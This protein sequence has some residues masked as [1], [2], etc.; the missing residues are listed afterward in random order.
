MNSIL[1]YYAPGD[2]I[3]VERFLKERKLAKYFSRETAAAVVSLGELL[4]RTP[5]DKAAPAYYGMGVV[6]HESFGLDAIAAASAGEGGGF[7]QKLF[8]EEGFM[9]VPPL[10]QF[11]VLYNMPLCFASIVFGLTGDNAVIYSSAAGLLRQ[12]LLAPSFPVLLGAGKSYTDGSVRACFAL[13]GR[14]ELEALLPLAGDKEAIEIFT[15][16]RP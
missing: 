1:N 13:A 4:Q 3:P 6:D 8:V 15:L 10:N 9:S 7:S 12:A 11:K 2:K 16:E 5:A 14:E